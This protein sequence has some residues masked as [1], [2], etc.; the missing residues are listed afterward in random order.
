MSFFPS[1]STKT[2]TMT[3]GGELMMSHHMGITSPFS[4]GGH[5]RLPDFLIQNSRNLPKSTKKRTKPSI[6]LGSL[7]QLVRSYINEFRAIEIIKLLKLLFLLYTP[8]RTIQYVALFPAWKNLLYSDQNLPHH[9]RHFS[10][11][12][13]VMPKRVQRRYQITPLN[14]FS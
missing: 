2:K 4:N 13:N 5:L 11:Y 12:G 10:G 9:V 14:H 8:G 6:C 7:E 3:L 1:A